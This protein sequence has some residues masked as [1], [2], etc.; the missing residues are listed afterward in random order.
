[1]D[2]ILD[3]ILGTFGE[4]FIWV[5]F[6]ILVGVL[7]YVFIRLS[8]YLWD[9]LFSIFNEDDINVEKRI[10]K[11]LEP[12]VTTLFPSNYPPIFK[13]VVKVVFVGLICLIPWFIKSR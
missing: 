5:G 1:M 10:N 2:D 6:V 7:F 12:L 8:N 4:N 3:W 13:I 11:S 9:K